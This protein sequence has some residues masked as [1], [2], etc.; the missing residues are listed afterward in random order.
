MHPEG[1]L[2]GVQNPWL[3][4]DS[5]AIFFK[6]SYPRGISSITSYFDIS[7]HTPLPIVYKHISPFSAD[8][9]T[10]Y[11][12]IFVFVAV[13]LGTTLNELSA[14]NEIVCTYFSALFGIFSLYVF[15]I[16][17]KTGVI[18]IFDPTDAHVPAIPVL[19]D[20]FCE[21][22]MGMITPK[23]PVVTKLTRK[24]P[25]LVVISSG[26]MLLPLSPITPVP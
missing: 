17:S 2:P 6:S 14:T 26:V 9:V 10:K 16:S 19:S 21:I 18:P 12:Y 23:S 5:N 4:M 7:E 22:S 8:P 3:F 13:A 11:V 15:V 25:E 24:S 20:C 1:V